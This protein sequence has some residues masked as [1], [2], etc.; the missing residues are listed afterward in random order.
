MP[1]EF[2]ERLLCPECEHGEHKWC[3]E[4]WIIPGAP[5][6]Y[7]GE[8]RY[9]ECVGAPECISNHLVVSARDTSEDIG[10]RRYRRMV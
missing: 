8:L 4:S 5:P 1:N 7:V 3:K 6:L 2:G 9:C 10:P